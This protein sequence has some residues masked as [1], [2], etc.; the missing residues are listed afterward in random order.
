MARNAVAR[1]GVRDRKRGG[2]VGGTGGKGTQK[3][4][5]TK[6]APL[7]YT[8]AQKLKAVAALKTV[9][10]EH[11]LGKPALQAAYDVLGTA[12]ATATLDRWLK[13]YGP[14]VDEMLPSRASALTLVND[15]H[16]SIVRD[17]VDVRGK[18]VNHLK[19]QDVI[20]KMSGRDAAVVAGIF[21]D[22]IIKM[23]G[24]SPE[25]EQLM[26]QFIA[27]C[28]RNNVDHKEAMAD[29]MQSLGPKGDDDGMIN[30]AAH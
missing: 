18:V 3:R 11:T 17:F 10:H 21:N 8:T 6:A 29:Y 4:T 27:Y 1:D 26:L 23:T 28:D 24:L 19:K 12:P 5:H 20:D 15:V 13:Q 25:D 7:R 2:G 30:V 22:H 14:Q 16:D 9:G